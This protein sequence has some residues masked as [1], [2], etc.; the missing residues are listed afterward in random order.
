MSNNRLVMRNLF[1]FL[2]ASMILMSASCSKNENDTS[3]L[4]KEA[5]DFVESIALF[6]EANEL[7]DAVY[8]NENIEPTTKEHDEIVKK[9]EE[10]LVLSQ[11]V[12]QDYLEKLKP[13]LGVMYHDNCAGIYKKILKSA[14]IHEGSNAGLD[15]S[16]ARKLQLFW[17]FLESNE[18]T[19]TSNLKEYSTRPV[20]SFWRM[21]FILFIADFV[22]LIAFSILMIAML[23]IAGI[24]VLFENGSLVFRSFFI[25]LFLVIASIIQSYFWVLWASFCSFSVLYYIDSP[26][27]NHTWLYYL[28]GFFAVGSPIAFLANKEVNS[29]PSVADQNSTLRGALMYKIISIAAFLV[30]IIWPKLSDH[31]IVSW[32]NDLIY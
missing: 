17:A 23:P 24:S 15:E 28:V 29:K 9:I 4:S 22:V 3:S 30:F 8:S 2:I 26:D 12:P 20:K 27:V 11:N 5:K 21:I 31:T 6:N 16:D 13:G 25:F 7:I 32:L 10:G 18:A 19:I 1:S 14:K